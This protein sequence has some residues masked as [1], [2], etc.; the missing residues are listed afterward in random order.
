MA[1]LRPPRGAIG[2]A[3][4]PVLI[5]SLGSA[6]RSLLPVTGPVNHRGNWDLEVQKV[7]VVQKQT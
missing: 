4:K 7:K 5:P 1:K 2:C 3:E 6:A